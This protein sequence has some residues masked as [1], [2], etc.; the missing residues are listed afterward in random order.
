MCDAMPRHPSPSSMV[1]KGL[2]MMMPPLA[3]HCHHHH[4]S[5]P[6]STASHCQ[7]FLSRG[8]GSIHGQHV[9]LPPPLLL[10]SGLSM[11]QGRDRDYVGRDEEVDSLDADNGML[12]PS[13]TF[14]VMMDFVCE[15]FPEARGP[16]PQDSAPLLPGM[17]RGEVPANAPC[18]RQAQ[19]ID[20]MMSQVS[21][22]LAHANRSTKPSFASI[23][24]NSTTDVIGLA[25]TRIEVVLQR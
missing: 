19:L 25:V 24:P 14:M 16:V 10:I 17:Q 13:S 7:V 6:H 8:T 9:V 12:D 15:T 2:D 21:E 11:S 22:G 4:Y 18:L 23:Q 20:F 1:P 5:A 3:T